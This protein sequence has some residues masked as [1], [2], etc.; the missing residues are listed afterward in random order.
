MAFHIIGTAC[1]VLSLVTEHVWLRVT[2]NGHHAG[3][4]PLERALMLADVLSS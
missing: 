4:G 3:F 2:L 1:N